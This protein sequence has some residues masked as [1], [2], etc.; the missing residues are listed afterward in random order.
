[1][2]THILGSPLGLC[3]LEFLLR[4]TIQP[5]FRSKEK[6]GGLP[7]NLCGFIA[8]DVSGT[9]IPTDNASF[10]IREEDRKIF[11]VLD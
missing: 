7:N 9:V 8:E 11:D 2:P 3:C 6:R 10:T 1:V 4:H 5:I